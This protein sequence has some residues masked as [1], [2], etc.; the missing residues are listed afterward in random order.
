MFRHKHNRSF[1][2]VLV[3]EHEL[4]YLSQGL[5]A[6]RVSGV[7]ASVRVVLTSPTAILASS[8]CSPGLAPPLGWC[9]ISISGNCDIPK[10]FASFLANSINMD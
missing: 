2:F 7:I 8:L 6:H 5:E 10:N 3:N 4:K 1:A 9:G